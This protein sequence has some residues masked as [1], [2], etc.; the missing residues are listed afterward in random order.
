M[1]GFRISDYRD[2]LAIGQD[3][4]RIDESRTTEVLWRADSENNS[5][6]IWLLMRTFCRRASIC[7]YVLAHV[8]TTTCISA[9]AHEQS[10][11]RACLHNL[12]ACRA[13]LRRAY[14]QAHARAHTHT[15]RMRVCARAYASSAMACV[16]H[17]ASAAMLYARSNIFCGAHRAHAKR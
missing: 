3:Q 5:H 12:C 11:G 15:A 7:T 6:A 4:W 10:D 9:R 14:A 2:T 16:P 8:R 1:R 17:N 13:H